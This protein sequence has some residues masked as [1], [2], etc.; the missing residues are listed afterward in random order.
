MDTE[1]A[2]EQR[3]RP[4]LN[5]SLLSPRRGLPNSNREPTAHAVSYVLPLLRSFCKK[6]RSAPTAAVEDVFEEYG[7]EDDMPVLCHR[8]VV[9]ELV[10]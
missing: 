4:G 6:L 10:G 1:Q 3:Q 9:A 8:D 7:A 5:R 2:A